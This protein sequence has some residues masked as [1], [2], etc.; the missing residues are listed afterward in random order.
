M[1]CER[2][3]LYNQTIIKM[4][5]KSILFELKKTMDGHLKEKKIC[6]K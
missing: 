1:S 5:E 4:T 3:Y 6:K 2:I